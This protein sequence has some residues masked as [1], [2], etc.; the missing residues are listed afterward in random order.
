MMNLTM[1]ASLGLPDAAAKY[2]ETMDPIW[3]LILWVTTFFFAIIV[4]TLILFMIKYRRREGRVLEDAPTHHTVLEAA[5]SIIPLIIVIVIFFIGAK[6]FNE[7]NVAPDN[8]YVIQVHAKTWSFSFSYPNGGSDSE[9]WVMKDQPVRLVMQSDDFLHGLYIPAFRAHRNVVPGRIVEMWFQATKLG[10]FPIECTQ[11]CGKGHSDMTTWVHV[12]TQ[13]E[14]D[15][16]LVA[17]ADPFHT[18]DAKT[19]K[20]VDVPYPEV[21]KK[22]YTQMGCN[23]CHALDE[24][25]TAGGGP[26]WG[27]MYL[28]TQKLDPGCAQSGGE[29]T[30]VDTATRVPTAKEFQDWDAYLDRAILDPNADIVTGFSRGVMPGNFASLLGGNPGEVNYLKRKAIIEYIKSL[31]DRYTKNP[32]VQ[33]ADKTIP[34]PAP[35]PGAAT[36][37]SAATVSA[38]KPENGKQ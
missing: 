37:A 31:S 29:I 5:W 7:S 23:A 28:Y 26:G 36:T 4:G 16:K 2:A 35:K 32:E 24:K 38:T 33:K 14:F 22:L 12:V 15:A 13:N 18:K 30:G 9:L 19:G 17:L 1:L 11:Y 21:G 27:N 34:G 8:A 10:D 6:G 25:R 20:M 3:D